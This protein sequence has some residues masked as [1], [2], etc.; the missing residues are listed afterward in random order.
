MAPCRGCHG[1]QLPHQ[2]QPLRAHVRP[3]PEHVQ[4]SRLRFDVLL[5]DVV[6][7]WR[8]RPSTRRKTCS[9]PGRTLAPQHQIRS[10]SSILA[11]PRTFLQRSTPGW[12]ECVQNAPSTAKSFAQ[13]CDEV[14]C[15][16]CTSSRATGASQCERPTAPRTRRSAGL[17]FE[18]S[19][20]ARAQIARSGEPSVT[21][22]Q[23][24]SAC[25]FGVRARMIT[26]NMRA[27]RRCR[28]PGARIFFRLGSGCRALSSTLCG[29]VVVV[30]S[31]A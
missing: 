17:Q 22:G 15:S 9:S 29:Q 31:E 30:T 28:R 5:V 8:R 21:R 18:C 3:W 11:R 7:M 6:F 25:G 4:L 16:F 1:G 12:R 19:G 26:A 24:R 23:R 27:P 14:S 20:S 2:V 13:G 10:P